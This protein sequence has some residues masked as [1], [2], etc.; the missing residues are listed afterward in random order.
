MSALELDRRLAPEG[1]FR[2][3]RLGQWWDGVDSWLGPNGRAI[4]DGLANPYEFV[5][6]APTWAGVDIGLKHDSSAVVTI[7]RRPDEE[8]HPTG[9][10]HM[11]CKLWLPRTDEPVD[12][13]GVMQYLRDI[14]AAY[15]LQEVS[16]DSRFFDVPAKYLAD[17]GLVMSEIPQSLERMTMAVGGLYEAILGGTVTHDGDQ[18]FTAQVMNAQPRFNE[19]GFTLAKGKSRGR[20][21]AAVAAALAVDRVQ[22]QEPA[23]PEA[24]Y[25]YPT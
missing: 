24:V 23:P 5:D 6:G 8:G 20:I 18:A 2:I 19:R 25:F 7:Q 12:V 17:E 1:H 4:W 13:T 21:D 3:F 22:R 11:I 10:L 15:D 14:D 9:R 16:Y